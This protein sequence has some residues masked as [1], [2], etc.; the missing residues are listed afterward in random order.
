MKRRTVSGCT[1][2]VTGS[3]S[4]IGRAL[5]V[6]LAKRRCTLLV[7]DLNEEGSGQTLE[8]VR[9]A[10]GAGEVFRCDVSRLDDVKRMADYCFDTWGKVDILV[11]NA[12]VAAAGIFEDIPIKDWEWIMSINLWGVIYGCHAFIPAMKKQ[13]SGYIVNVASAAGIIS[14]PEMS[15]YNVTK[16]GVIS[17]SET[18]KSEL[19]PNN[20]GVTVVC[21]TFLNTNLLENMRYTDDFQR[22]FARMAFGY[23]KISADT[24]AEMT[25]RAVEKDK[26][27]VLPQLSAKMLWYSKRLSPSS[28]FG[29]L[30][31]LNRNGWARSFM[32]KM[33]RR[34]ML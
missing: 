32:M 24:I 5:A 31:F 8:M 13:G 18:L 14:S 7:A 10:G 6:S 26:L 15:S 25:V 28:H 3:A 11:N 34:G 12:G 23:A 29:W 30:A 1:A 17:L 20:I 21:P 27:Y 16:A 19:S 9:Q 2:V 22:D 4:G 33:A